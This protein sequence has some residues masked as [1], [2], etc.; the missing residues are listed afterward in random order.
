MARKAKYPN[1]LTI[2][3]IFDL[4][5]TWFVYRLQPDFSAYFPMQNLLKMLCNTSSELILP[6]ISPR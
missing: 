6:T 2:I 1:Y 5:Y 4:L 3:P